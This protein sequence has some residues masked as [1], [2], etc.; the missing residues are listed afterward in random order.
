[1]HRQPKSFTQFLGKHLHLVGLNPL[2]ATHAQRKPNHNLP[3]VVLLNHPLQVFKV[4][5]LRRPLQS[6]QPLRRNPQRIRHRNPN[7]ARAHVE[8][9][10]P[11]VYSRSLINS[12][13]FF[14]IREGLRGE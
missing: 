3:H 6:I 12:E 5:P 8:T 10:N 9:K 4:L 1:M 2:R 7:P 14:N 11:P 13:I